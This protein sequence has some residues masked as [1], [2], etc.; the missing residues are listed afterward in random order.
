M[1]FTRDGKFVWDFGHRPPAEAGMMPEN[2]QET[3]FLI[4]KG[5]FQIDEV[6]NEIYIIQ[7]KRVLIYD[8]TTG[9]YKRGWGGHGMPLERNLERAHSALQVDRRAA[10]ARE[11]LRA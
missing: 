10:A 8:A 11:E 4:N 7:Q 6:A 1:K 3:S 2:N 9:A 5:R